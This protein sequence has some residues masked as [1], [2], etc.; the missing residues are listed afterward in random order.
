[1]DRQ[2]LPKILSANQIAGF[3]DIIFEII[4]EIIVKGR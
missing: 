2:L 4:F 1:M 3:F